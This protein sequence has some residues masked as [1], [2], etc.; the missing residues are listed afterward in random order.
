[1]NTPSDIHRI[2]S[3]L[4]LTRLVAQREITE[5]LRSRLI[6]VLTVLTALLV[7][8]LI[9]VP[10]L[11]RQPSNPMLIGLVGPSAQS[12]TKPLQQSAAAARIDIQVVDVVSAADARSELE[13]GTIDVALRV[14]PH[15]AVAEVR[16][17]TQGKLSSLRAQT[18]SPAVRALL[19]ATVNEAHQQSVL[20][21]A[22]VPPATV[23]EALTPVPLS[24]TELQSPPSD[25]AARD[26]AAVAAA[27]L[28]YVT[29]GL[30]GNTIASSVA[31]EKTS[32]AAEIL[33]AT[34][35]PGQLL[36]GKVVGIGIC[37]V[38]Q[39]AVA[40]VAGLIANAV[41][42]SALIPSTV[43]VLL[44]TVLLWFVLGYTLYSFAFAA[45]GALVG[46]QEDVQFVT[47]PFTV[48]LVGGFLLTYLAI[49]TPNAWWIRVLSFLPP[50]APILMPARLAVGSI[51][52]WEMPLAVLIMLVAI[53]GMVRLTARIYSPALVRGGSRLSWR[54]ALRL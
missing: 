20:R 15:S 26:V 9:V 33:L 48:P 44:P 10:A 12:L 1:M 13:K 50:L 47:L 19:Q 23:L 40:V 18:L 54:A 52:M 21:S 7:V 45:A 5:R 35:R 24:T 22:G 31:Q 17:A 37:S 38:G 16:G 28:L 8:A 46:R 4:A 27:I 32:R 3:W 25:Q 41:V 39:L 29:L 11:I 43:W 2:V 34:V 30:Y 42:Q 14:G 51:A 53:Y 36:I 6:R 49:A